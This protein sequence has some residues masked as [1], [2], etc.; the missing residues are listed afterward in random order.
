MNLST[1][2]N[3]N[4]ALVTNGL[5]IAN[6]ICHVLNM[7][8]LEIKTSTGVKLEG[9]F[10]SQEQLNESPESSFFIR[11]ISNTTAM[12]HYHYLYTVHFFF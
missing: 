11:H 10:L 5:Q 7:H 1:A 3:T 2:G 8:L 9:A 6:T 4:L 12:Y